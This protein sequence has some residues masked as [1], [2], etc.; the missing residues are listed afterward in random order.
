MRPPPP[1][2]TPAPVP[3]HHA[4]P[5]LRDLAVVVAVLIIV[6]ALSGRRRDRPQ[7]VIRQPVSPGVRKARRAL[8]VIVAGTAALVLLPA[9]LAVVA[10]IILAALWKLAGKLN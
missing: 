5:S 6:A 8:A 7:I 3:A 4:P 9:Q 1:W 2:P 10:V